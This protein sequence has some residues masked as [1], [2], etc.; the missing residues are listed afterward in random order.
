[1]LEKLAEK[2]KLLPANPGV[3]FHRDKDGNIIYVGKAANLRARVKSYFNK[4]ARKDV[5]TRALVEDI[6]DVDWME[7]ETELDALFLES[8]MIKRY[9]PKYNILL[10]DD[11]NVMYLKINFKDE[12]P[13]VEWTREPQDDGAEYLGPYYSGGVVKNAMRVL[14]RGFPYFAKR[15]PSR[16]MKQMGLEPVIEN[17]VDAKEYKSNLRKL[18]RILRGERA[19]MLP[20]LE[21]EMNKAA[22]DLDFEKAE[23]LKRQVFALKALRGQIVFA[24]KEWADLSSDES[25]RD[26]ADILGLPGAGDLKR[27]EGFDI[28]HQSGK[29]V[30][31][32]QVVFKNGVAS[33]MDYRKYKMRQEKND[34]TANMQEA[35][36]RRM[37]HLEEWG[38]PDLILVDG[39]K[40]QV[41][42]VADVLCPRGLKYIGIAERQEEIIIEREKSGVKVDRVS[43][44]R[45]G[46]KMYEND[47]FIT[48]LLPENS[49]VVK[50]LQRVRDEAHRFAVNYHT[51]LKRRNALKSVQKLPRSE[52]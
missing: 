43:V 49:P 8:E 52:K 37:R 15:Q 31:A 4:D 21:K 50:L 26:L 39:G 11:K 46:G 48:I 47:R 28:S 18:L 2:L 40:G 5:K 17:D 23:K 45:L 35:V 30:V 10:R 38:R 41:E 14:R 12:I 19:R 1:M 22:R 24:D 7:T 27:I 33:R 32:S 9:K 6:V 29:N 34:D 16:L 25:L 3:Y 51:L 42:A 36:V 13:M 44:E 20:V